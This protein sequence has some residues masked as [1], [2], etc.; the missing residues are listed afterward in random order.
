[1]DWTKIHHFIPREFDDPEF[2]DSGLRMDPMS[3]WIL[4]CLRRKT[5]WRI[6]VLDAVDVRGV[7]HATNS[8]HNLEQG[9]QAVDFYFRTKAGFREQAKAVLRSGFTGIG[10]YQEWDHPGFHLDRREL[11]QVWKRE[12]GEYIYLLH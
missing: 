3:V 8:F 10:T 12:K 2:P 9:A 11:F 4:E 7:R 1:M 5:G 6:D